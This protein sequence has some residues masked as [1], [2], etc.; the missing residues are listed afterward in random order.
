MQTILAYH[1]SGQMVAEMPIED[2]IGDG[3]LLVDARHHLLQLRLDTQEFGR[4]GLLGFVVVLACL[5]TAPRSSRLVV[6]PVVFAFAL[7]RFGLLLLLFGADHLLVGERI[8][9]SFAY[10]YQRQREES[11]SRNGFVVER[12]E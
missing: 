1:L 12:R 8:G 2:T 10:M 9:F 5:G 11:H 6:F 7:T 4:K 3:H